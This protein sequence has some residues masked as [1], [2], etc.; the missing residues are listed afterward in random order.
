MALS[1]VGY[2]SAAATSV[3]LP[4]FTAGDL[5][6]VFAYRDGSNT[7]PSL[8]AGWT[9]IESSG[10]GTNSSRTG[11]RVLQASDTTT[12][13]WANATAVQ[14]EVL[15]GQ[16]LTSPVGQLTANGTNSNTIG[17]DSVNVADATAA[18]TWLVGFAGHRTATDV[19]S[20]TYSGM[21]TRS[22]GSATSDLSCHTQA[23]SFTDVGGGDFWF[24]EV[25][26]VVNASSG[27]RSLTIEILAAGS[28]QTST[29]EV[30]LQPGNVPAARTDHQIVLRARKTGLT[31]I[32]RV[33]LYE[34]STAR[35]TVL[36]T[37]ELTTSLATYT[38]DVADS[39]A[40][41]ITSYA[42]LSVR[43]TGYSA[44]GDATVFEVAAADL[45]IPAA[46][47]GTSTGSVDF[48]VTFGAS[49]NGQ[50][51]SSGD[52]TTSTFEVSLASADTPATR[53]DH[54]I[55]VRARV[56][57]GAHVGT[58][59]AQLYE[60]TTP[61]SAVLE[62][63]ALTAS[64][65]DYALAI[66]DADAATITDYSNLSVRVR[67]YASTG[68]AAVFEVA[69]VSAVIPE[70]GVATVTGAV[71]LAST[72]TIQVGEATASGPIYPGAAVYPHALITLSA[73]GTITAAVSALHTYGSITAP[74]VFDMSTSGQQPNEPFGAALL[75]STATI[76]V[77]G[78]DLDRIGVVLLDSTATITVGGGQDVSG[79][80]TLS[81]TATITVA[82]VVPGQ[83][84]DADFTAALP[85]M[86]SIRVAVA[87]DSQPLETIQL[88]EAVTD[89]ARDTS[90][91]RGR[92]F[93]LDRIEAG[94]AH[95][96]LDNLDGRFNPENTASP[97]YPNLKP[98]KRLRVS[99]EWASVAYHLF[100]GFLEGYPQEYPHT[101]FDR[102][103]SQDAVDAYMALALAKF[104]PGTTSLQSEMTTPDVHA[105]TTGTMEEIISVG[106]TALPMPQTVPFTVT[107]DKDTPHP[108]TMTVLEILSAT[109]WLV[110]RDQLKATGHTFG[111]VVSTEVVSFGEELTG[112][113]INHV[114]ERINLPLTTDIDAGI[115]LLAASDNLAGQSPLEHLQ[116]AAEAEG[117]RLFVAVDG[118]LTFHSRHHFYLTETSNRAVFGD[119][120]GTELTYIDAKVTHEDEKLF[121]I[122]RVTPAS[123]NV[124]EVRDQSSIDDHFER[125]L[126]KQWPLADDNEA[127]A[128]AEYLLSRLSRMQVRIPELVLDG[129]ADPTALWPVMLGVEIGQRYGFKLRPR[130]G[131]QMIDKTLVVEGVS[132]SVRPDQVRSN[133]QLSLADTTAYWLLDT[134]ELDT[135]TILAY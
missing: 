13:V 42:N 108:E 87:F 100:T 119:G 19:N 2:A 20:R 94:N 74:F 78:N 37:G 85:H 17:Y 38:L 132:Y 6:L 49:L 36:E 77:V 46:T 8:P 93:E 84:A 83:A 127:L 130:D 90:T 109:T 96:L 66:A 55:V 123:G 32:L 79:A 60:G 4:A 134:S 97:Y 27:W 110:E 114:L 28:K 41:T 51:T 70:S 21:T 12:G 69:A 113:R 14:V 75:A 40:A 43:L 9:N 101:G 72:A 121:N 52:K 67:G 30:S 15:R 81:A 64:L 10:A 33:Q 62:S 128:A 126:E 25:T 106:S 11:W 63:G 3:A 120:G 39:D 117:G 34:G 76:T 88:Y 56:T 111:A 133:V 59:R 26:A 131:S 24:D 105:D 58:I 54:S 5:A 31:G 103:V 122:V 71:L 116:L 89:Y 50:A 57:N 47:G 48:P 53:T 124:Q 91:K 104:I 16:H 73:T 22:S 102:V 92:Q 118:T 65:S 23:D 95:L 125:A 99:A 112:T 61:R 115:A 68:D 1:H 107:I 7:A 98:T 35:S 45:R 80:A 129:A 44:A 82:G 86:P 135:E 29:A 18:T